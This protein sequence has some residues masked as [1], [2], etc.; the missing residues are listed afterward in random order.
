MWR[1]LLN[2]FWQQHDCYALMFTI[3]SLKWR[4]LGL[5]VYYSTKTSRYR[6]IG[7]WCVPKQILTWMLREARGG[8]TATVGNRVKPDYHFIRIVFLF[9]FFSQILVF[10]GRLCSKPCQHILDIVGLSQ[11]EVWRT[12]LNLFNSHYYSFMKTN[13]TIIKAY[14]NT[15]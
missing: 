10:P 1:L 7:L 12:Y 8:L 13:L 5:L 14:Q 15:Y 9:F 11:A 3:K 6:Q 4:Y 2:I